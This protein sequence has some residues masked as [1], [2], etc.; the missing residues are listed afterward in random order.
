MFYSELEVLRDGSRHIGDDATDDSEHS[1][2]DGEGV[3]AEDADELL[4]FQDLDRCEGDDG[5]VIYH[6]YFRSIFGRSL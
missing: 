2:G 4:Y 3:V 1:G 5:G 6:L